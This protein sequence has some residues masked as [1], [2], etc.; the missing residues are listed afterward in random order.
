[1]ANIQT[2]LS[3]P[4]QPWEAAKARFLEG[5][6]TEE[7]SRFT[8]ATLENLFY[9]ASSA[10]KKHTGGSRSWIMQERLASLADGLEDYGKA[11]DVYSNASSLILCPIW[12]S[13][14]V[15]L[16]IASEAGKF[17]EKVVDMLAHI[18]DAIPRFRIYQA[19]FGRHER[20]LSALTDAYLDVL[21]FCTRTKDFF[22]R[23]KKSLSK[24]T[25]REINWKPFRQEFDAD[26]IRF[27]KHQKSVEKEASLAHKIEAAKAREIELAQRMEGDRRRQ[28]FNIL[29]AL[30]TVDY[31]TKHA[32][33]SSL[34]YIGTNIWVQ[35]NKTYQRWLGSRLSTCLPC[36]GIPGSGKSVLAASVI[37]TLADNL[38]TG[39]VLCYYYCDYTDA[40][41][42]DSSY[43]IAS[44]IKQLLLRL[45]LE[46]IN[47][48]LDCPFKDGRPP[49]TAR[50]SRNFLDRLL[51]EFET[52]FFVI[53][54]LDELSPEHQNYALELI[55]HF[56]CTSTPTVKIFVTSRAE[57]R[58]IKLSLKAHKSIDL[59]IPEV[60]QDISMFIAE[61]VDKRA[62]DQNPIL[63]SSKIKE[64]VVTTLA[65]GA[66]GM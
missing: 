62:V 52:V 37:D 55:A 50:A 34:R 47:N 51:R 40:D 48:D 59:S 20:L 43:I 9:D 29:T 21:R 5:L 49:P 36:Y 41:S 57:E 24:P 10:Q 13:L 26:M 63:K 64:E 32:K 65:R 33:L 18:G 19:L 30:R 31:E 45:P 3:I 39:S 4:T 54:A 17:Q 60:E 23:A 56:L 58:S 38:D 28:R 66:K 2:S 7:A 6:T 35:N 27:H 8:S 46:R 42:L 25:T 44:L 61:M 11:L 22:K 14:R 1:M 53:D 12:G 15:V 16:H